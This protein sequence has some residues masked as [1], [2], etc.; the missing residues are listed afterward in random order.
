MPGTVFSKWLY[1]ASSLMSN[2]ITVNYKGGFKVFKERYYLFMNILNK[3]L[4]QFLLK[5][6][7]QVK[8]TNWVSRK[9]NEWLGIL[10][11]GIALTTFDT[12]MHP[13]SETLPSLVTVPDNAMFMELIFISVGDITILHFFYLQGFS[14]SSSHYSLTLDMAV[15]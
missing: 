8:G 1:Y 12:E 6:Q 13:S 11:E 9:E 4:A 7:W 10:Q 14:L 15:S 2:T 3:F 5:K